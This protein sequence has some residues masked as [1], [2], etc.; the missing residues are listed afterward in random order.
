MLVALTKLIFYMKER[1][2]KKI[3]HL[4]IVVT[5]GKFLLISFLYLSLI[6]ENTLLKQCLQA[7][8]HFRFIK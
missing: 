1:I 5:G 7:I 4:T 6:S 8:L 2:L 3:K